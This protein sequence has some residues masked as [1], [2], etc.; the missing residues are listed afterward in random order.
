MKY[1][2]AEIIKRTILATL[3]SSLAPI[4]WLKIGQ[5]IGTLHFSPSE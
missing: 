1:V 2:K 3:M 5:I 4:A